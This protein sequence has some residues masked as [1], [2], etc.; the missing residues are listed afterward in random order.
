MLFMLMN[1]YC[2]SLAAQEDTGL[3]SCGNT[4]SFTEFTSSSTNDCFTVNDV[5]SN[6]TKIWVKINMHFFVNDD[7]SG[8]L[9]P[10]HPEI[11]TNTIRTAYQKA[12]DLI[13]WFNS[14]LENNHEQWNQISLWG[15]NTVQPAQ[16][17][18]IRYALSGVYVHCNSTARNTSGTNLPYFKDNFAVNLSSE[19]NAFF[20]EWIGTSGGEASYTNKLFSTEDFSSGIFNHEFG[21]CGSLGHVFDNDACTDTP[22]IRFQIDFNCDGDIADEFPLGLGDEDTWRGCFRHITER[23]PMD[24]DGDDDV[25]YADACNP[26]QNCLPEPCC[27]WEYQNN[28]VMAYSGYTGSD[29]A[30]T[31][32]QINRMLNTLSGSNYCSYI[33]QIGGNCPPPMANI[34]VFPDESVSEDCSYCFQLMASMNEDKYKVEILTMND[35]LIYNH[36]WTPDDARIFCISR[37]PKFSSAYMYGL[38][39]NT[40]YKLRLSLISPCETEAVEEYIFRLPALPSGGCLV[41]TAP[42]YELTGYYPNPFESSLTVEYDTEV[43]GKMD[44]FLFPAGSGNEI[45]LSSEYVSQPG[46]YQE[47]LNTSAVPTGTYFLALSLDGVIISKTT[48]KI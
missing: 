40:D 47:V 43:A 29:G 33:E 45:L 26:P 8:I 4:E 2:Y 38:Q 5:Q 11:D 13:N 1:P 31:A 15:I 46:S 20:V 28:N 23:S 12:D 27:K 42:Q 14:K 9:N 18:P 17:N 6:C 30:F 16:C 48:L 10:I 35:N 34:H 36:G 41:E 32:C 37:N 24:Y 3:S 39:A 21:H 19:F 44:I 22:R 25:D 7:C